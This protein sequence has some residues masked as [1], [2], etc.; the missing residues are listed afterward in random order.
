MSGAGLPC[1]TSSPATID[2]ERVEQPRAA[3]R[4]LQ[5][6]ARLRRRHRDRHAA[7]AQRARGA[8]TASSNGS[9]SLSISANSSAEKLSQNGSAA[10]SVTRSAKYACTRG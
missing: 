5:P 6:L 2:V 9:S 3:E 8:R 4:A 1:S 7:L 10:G